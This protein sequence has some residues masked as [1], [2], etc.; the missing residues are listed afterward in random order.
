MEK[1]EAQLD[2]VFGALADRTRRKI[3][4]QVRAKDCTVLELAG[5]FEMSLPAVSKH[6]KVLGKSGLLRRTKDG[7]F[8][9]CKYEP[10]PMRDAI[11][12]IS[13]QHQFWDEGLEALEAFLDQEATKGN[14]K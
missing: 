14:E 5:Q 12:W 10:E 7:R 8:V 6:L 13:R 11:A 9:V 3:L 2:L 1:A 4:E